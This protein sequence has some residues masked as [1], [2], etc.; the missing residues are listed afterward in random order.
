[1]T[2]TKAKMDETSSYPHVHYKDSYGTLHISG[3]GVHFQPDDGSTVDLTLSRNALINVSTSC[4]AVQKLFLLNV[5]TFTDGD[6]HLISFQMSNAVDMVKAKDKIEAL[7]LNA[8]FIPCSVTEKLAE[9]QE[10]EFYAF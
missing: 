10:S 4:F 2:T 5:A 1:M 3:M 7:L 6:S 8:A 9:H